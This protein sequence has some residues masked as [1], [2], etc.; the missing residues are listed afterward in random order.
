MRTKTIE[1]ED[2]RPGD[3]RGGGRTLRGRRPD[4]VVVTCLLQKVNADRGPRWP[5]E[6]WGAG[7]HPAPHGWGLGPRGPGAGGA[8]AWK[9]KPSWPGLRLGA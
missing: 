3:R 6:T 2:P 7:G 5:R 1:R 8:Q 4:E 9:V